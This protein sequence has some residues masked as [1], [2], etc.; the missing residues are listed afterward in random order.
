M[1]R[2]TE[3]ELQSWGIAALRIMVGAVLM[4]HGVQKLVLYG[5]A[6]TAGFWAVWP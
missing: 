3:S 5:L 4:A 6:G 2:F 1:K